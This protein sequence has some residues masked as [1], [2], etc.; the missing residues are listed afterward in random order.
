VYDTSQSPPVHVTPRGRRRTVIVPVVLAAV[1]AL[2]CV[3]ALYWVNRQAPVTV[4]GTMTITE[5]IAGGTSC[6]G[7]Q[8]FEDMRKG[9]SVV[10]R[11]TSG[12]IIGVGELAGG[13]GD[14][15]I[16]GNAERCRFAFH[17]TG[18]PRQRSYD[19]R[20]SYRPARRFTAAQV[21]GGPVEFS[22]GS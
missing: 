7:V 15:L 2:V 22:L 3:G 18:V 5:N 14:R 10:V 11:D 16:A 12:E 4:S 20:V 21:D 19:V 8:G 13:V 17:V 6:M 1:A 9:A